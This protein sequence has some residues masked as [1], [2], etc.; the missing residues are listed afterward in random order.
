MRTAIDD[1]TIVLN[2]GITNYPAIC[3]HIAR[4]RPAR[5]FTSG[6]GSLGWNGGAA[7]GMKL[8]APGQDGG[9]A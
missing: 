8:A 4:T 2:E 9:R 3:D 5:I 6:G 7:I 1:D